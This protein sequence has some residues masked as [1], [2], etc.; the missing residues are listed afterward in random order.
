MRAAIWIA[1]LAGG[2][3]PRLVDACAGVS[4]TCLSLQIDGSGGIGSI[5]AAVVHVVAG[6]IDSQ[7]NTPMS[8]RG[9]RLVLPVALALSFGQLAPGSS[10]DAEITVEGWL[11]GSLAGVGETPATLLGGRHSTATVVLG[12]AGDLG[13]SADGD[14]GSSSDLADGPPAIGSLI[15]EPASATLMLVHGAAP[16]TQTFACKLHGA[17][18]DTD[19]TSS[20]SWSLADPSIGSMSGATFSTSGAHGGA[21]RV[22]ATMG[23]LSAGADLQLDVKG[24]FT[25]ADCSG[26]AAFP[27][28]GAPACTG[29]GAP[30]IVYPPDGVMLPPNLEML[31][32]QYLP[33]AAYTDFEIDFES[34]STTVAL[35]HKCAQPVNGGCVVTLD[36]ATWDFIARSNRGGA[37]TLSVRGTADGS[38]ATVSSNQVKLSFAEG[39]VAG[40]LYYWKSSISANGVGGQVW[41]KSFGDTTAEAQV[42]GPSIETNGTACNGCH[43]VSRDGLRM[44][45]NGDDDDSDDEYSDMQS[46]LINLTT[47]QFITSGGVRVADG[48]SQPPGFQTFSPDHTMVLGSSGDGTGDNDNGIDGGAG[49]GNGFFLW[50]GDTGAPL[51]P[52]VLPVG[53]S[54]QRPTQPDWSAD[55][56]IVV[57]VMPSVVLGWAGTKTHSD[58]A[59]LAGGSLWTLPRGSG[60]FGTPQP[61]LQSQGE[62]NYYPS[63]SPDGNFVIFDRVPF[64]PAP[65]ASPSPDPANDSFSN[66]KARVTI[67]STA[68]AAQPIDCAALNALGD[69]SNSWP[70]W[71][72]I[73][74]TNNGHKLAWVTFSS[75]RD[76]GFVLQN[77]ALGMVQCYPPDSVQNPFGAH[78]GAF[79]SNCRAPQIWMAAIDLTAAAMGADPSFAAFWLPYQDAT[80]HNHTAQW[81]PR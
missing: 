34:A 33:G 73:L 55:G 23:A 25:D 68:P 49:G 71:S 45:V 48:L 75:T 11:N 57:F 76:Y 54:G 58:D 62:N 67:L 29:T 5:D 53:A 56:Q 69:L 52:A 26:C 10:T 2:C 61:L 81:S 37:V 47:K 28:P 17:D 18:G 35:E 8:G 66:P 74:T 39:D 14:A 27:A 19:V 46:G 50:D 79:P 78:A 43:S 22:T 24:S 63:Y 30:S 60:V 15:V 7:K 64:Q 1:L 72:P 38:C 6:A 70:R 42:T 21:T 40:A 13:L 44:V 4:G 65:S 51:S 20:C 36:P 41:R 77:N 31:S 32:I 59:H 16:A 9:P 12:G 80:T 3:G